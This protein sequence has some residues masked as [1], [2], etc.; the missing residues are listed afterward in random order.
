MAKKKLRKDVLIYRIVFAFM[1]IALIAIIVGIVLVIRSHKTTT[2]DTETTT[3]VETSTMNA[4]IIPVDTA[5]TEVDTAGET[6]VETESEATGEDVTYITYAL[7]KGRVNLREEP[8]TD[9]EVLVTVETGTQVIFLG[10]ADDGWVQVQYED[11]V[12]Y[13]SSQYVTILDPEPVQ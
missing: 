7:A 13:M 2:V 9:C 12:G 8:N 4:P 10:E 3:Q 6:E 1:C 11:Y 5:E